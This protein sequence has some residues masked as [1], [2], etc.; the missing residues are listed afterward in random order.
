MNPDRNA[1]ILELAGTMPMHEIARVVG[2]TY[3]TVN[4]VIWRF[5]HPRGRRCGPRQIRALGQAAAA[6]GLS[7]N[8]IRA[9]A[10][11]RAGQ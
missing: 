2:T 7:V 1:R 3:A 4:N 5:K 9:I 8:D 10:E 11:Q 6:A